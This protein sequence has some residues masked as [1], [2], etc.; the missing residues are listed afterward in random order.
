MPRHRSLLLVDNEASSVSVRSWLRDFFSPRREMQQSPA[1][2]APGTLLR[3]IDL[4][5]S[6]F[7]AC[8]GSF[9][10]KARNK[11]PRLT[12]EAGGKQKT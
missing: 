9:R 10:K 8:E 2:D 12:E 1:S 6:N 3:E 4:G 7:P 11:F 5:R